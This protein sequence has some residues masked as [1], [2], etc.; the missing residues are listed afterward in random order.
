VAIKLKGGKGIMKAQSASSIKKAE[1]LASYDLIYNKK[2]TKFESGIYAMIG[3]IMH[4]IHEEYFNAIV[5]NSVGNLKHDIDTFRNIVANNLALIQD[6]VIK[7]EVYNI[8]SLL[9]P[10]K[11]LD[12]IAFTKGVPERKLAIDKNGKPVDFFSNDAYARGIIDVHWA[13]G[14]VLNILDYKTN[15]QKIEDMEQLEFYAWLTREYY[16]ETNPNIT[17]I[18]VYYAYLRF[19][20]PLVKAGE[21]F[22]E[23]I[24]TMLAPK[25]EEKIDKIVNATE[26]PPNPSPTR[27]KFCEV[28]YACPLLKEFDTIVL[29]PEDQITEEDAKIYAH[30]YFVAESAVEHL[31]PLVEKFL[32]NSPTGELDL[33]SEILY[34]QSKQRRILKYD[35][36]KSKLFKV[37]KEDLINHISISQTLINK[38]GIETDDED[39]EVREYKTLTT[40]PKE[41][42]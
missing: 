22:V 17:N 25:F 26:F 41:E 27:C 34:F 40:R 8:S 23:E 7:D 37:K 12:E 35:K 14:N 19:P 30:T 21:F 42:N 18:V 3:K 24:D 16:K 36:I 39:Y 1:C 31:K 32:N 10:S 13:D 9:D 6:D 33:G 28:S 20:S 2:L 5:T 15:A 38:L 4:K 29:K 11:Y